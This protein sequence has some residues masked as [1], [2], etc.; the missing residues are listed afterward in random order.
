MHTPSCPRRTWRGARAPPALKVAQLAHGSPLSSGNGLCAGSGCYWLSMCAFEV[1]TGASGGACAAPPVYSLYDVARSDHSESPS[2]ALQ[3]RLGRLYTGWEGGGGPHWEKGRLSFPRD[4]ASPYFSPAPHCFFHLLCETATPSAPRLHFHVSWPWATPGTAGQQLSCRCASVG[5]PPPARVAPPVWSGKKLVSA[6]SGHLRESCAGSGP[7]KAA[8]LC[9]RAIRG[10]AARGRQPRRPGWP[11]CPGPG[12]CPP[13]YRRPL[14]APAPA[15]CPCRHQP[16]TQS[17]T[18][19][20]LP[21]SSP[22]SVPVAQPP[23]PPI[24]DTAHRQQG[25]RSRP[26]PVPWRP[27]RCCD[28]LPAGGPSDF[29]AGPLQ[30]PLR[31][32]AQHQRPPLPA[33][34]APP[35]WSAARC[36]AACAVA[37]PR[38]LPIR[39]LKLPAHNQRRPPCT[40]CRRFT[41][42]TCSA[43]AARHAATRPRT[44]T[45]PPLPGLGTSAT[46]STRL[47]HV[48]PRQ[49]APAPPAAAAPAAAMDQP[50][51][52]P[53]PPSPPG[54]HSGGAA[55]AT[56]PA[57]ARQPPR[58]SLQHLRRTLTALRRGPGSAS[59]QARRACGLRVAGARGAPQGCLSGRSSRSLLAGPLPPCHAT[60]G[61]TSCQRCLLYTS[62]RG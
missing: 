62:R 47:P 51:S 7:V 39:P 23:P 53:R 50:P 10:K 16:R 25:Q 15:T 11:A 26:D 1:Q 13:A 43:V 12:S 59:G 28:G 44:A 24:L 35:P 56:R 55:A 14:P 19:P 52:P 32:R 45:A 4:P 58:E 2:A 46:A 20:V 61:G 5:W 48:A 37:H 38:H 42:Y 8:Q 57:A 6:V 21:H 54:P 3:T 18:P 9:A 34:A 31:A 41:S 33:P 27:A 60:T 30:Q 17:A 22:A 40:W 29:R 49:R 36:S